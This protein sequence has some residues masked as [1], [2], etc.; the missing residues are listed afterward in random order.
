MN[1][2]FNNAKQIRPKH[3]ERCLCWDKFEKGFRCYVYDDISKY[4]C[5][6][7]TTEH[8]ENGDNHI[9]DYADYQVTMWTSLC[10]FSEEITK[11][12]MTKEEF[13][14]IISVGDIVRIIGADKEVD[15][16]VQTKTE[17]AVNL[18]TIEKGE[19]GLPLASYYRTY[20]EIIAKIS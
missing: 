17:Y 1:I 2:F 8:D 12:T 4:W 10:G 14:A 3:L 13:N 18:L 15:C 6:Q 7:S 11:K 9:V 20:D 19:S 5:T 16:V